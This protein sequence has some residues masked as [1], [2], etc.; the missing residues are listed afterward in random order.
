MQIS[1]KADIRRAVK[2]LKS[3]KKQIP[4]AT[5]RALTATAWDVQKEEI[6]Q[7]PMKLDRPT[8]F[9]KLAFGVKKATKQHLV[10]TV[11]VKPIQI[12]YLRFQIRGGTRRPWGRA[13]AV[14][15][16]Q[17]VDWHGNL[18]R[19]TINALLDDQDV[20]SGTVKGISGIWQRIDGGN[21]KLLIAWEPRTKYT[22]RFPFYKIGVGKARAVFTRNMKA[23][24]DYALRTAK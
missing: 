10:A 4:F 24:I 5:A 3:A 17:M 20:F 2:K 19:G 22:A 15:W 16:G 1:M 21:V 12:K 7:L 18:S 23:A 13:L 9:T 14:P 11:F 6:R 8:S